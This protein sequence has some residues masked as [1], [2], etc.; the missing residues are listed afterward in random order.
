MSTRSRRG[1]PIPEI[2]LD[3]ISELERKLI[4]LEKE[5]KTD[6]HMKEVKT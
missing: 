5:Y 6:E 4:S 3:K 1:E 2:L